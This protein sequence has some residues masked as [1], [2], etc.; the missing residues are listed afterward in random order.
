MSASTKTWVNGLAPTCED[1]DLNGFKTENNNLIIGSGQGL[2]TGD[3]QQTHKAVAHYAAAGDYYA[4]SGIV[5]AYVLSVTGVQVAPVTYATG[6]RIR[7]VAVN[8]NTTACT[9]NVAGMGVKDLL[10]DIGGGVALL[11]GQVPGDSLTE[12]YYDGTA[13]RVVSSRS[14]VLSG[15][16]TPTFKGETVAGTG[17][18]YVSQDGIFNRV[19]NLL[20]V[21]YYCRA[22]VIGTS[23]SG[24]LLLD[25][26]P[27]A[28]DHAIL[29]G[30]IA[31][32]GAVSSLNNIILRTDNA[33]IV[34]NTQSAIPGQLRFRENSS[35][36]HTITIADLSTGD[37]II[38]GSITIP[39]K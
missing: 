24:N 4:V 13:F 26:I 33:D 36:P 22:D 12:A 9:V 29:T 30:G 2:N 8:T 27:F 15:T 6:M 7:F 37:T 31:V 19:G 23:A 16:W 20:L 25:G 1:V 5:N 32:T 28:V 18:S 3:N 17:W 34:S 14:D 10:W 39:L 38:A 35:T 21:S 11:A